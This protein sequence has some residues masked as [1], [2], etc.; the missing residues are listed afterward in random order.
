MIEG[1]VGDKTPLELFLQQEQALTPSDRNFCTYL[2]NHRDRIINYNYYQA[3]NICPKGYRSAYAIASLHK[4]V[5]Y[6]TY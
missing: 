3:E 5:N 6:L 4:S 2:E 1:K